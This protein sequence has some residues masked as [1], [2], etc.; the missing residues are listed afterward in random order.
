MKPTE[1]NRRKVPRDMKGRAVDVA[2]LVETQSGSVVSREII[3]KPAGTVTVFAFDKD[4]ALSEHTAPF[5][6]LVIALDGAAEIT[7]AGEARLVRKG[8]MIIMP[9]GI[10]HSLKAV[11][12]FKMLLVMIKK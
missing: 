8:Q 4:G 10:P 5:D 1:R 11:S 6:A 3:H 2:G 7:L 12:A 9:A